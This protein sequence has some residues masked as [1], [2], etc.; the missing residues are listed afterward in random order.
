MNKPVEKLYDAITDID[1]TFIEKAE[2][3]LPTTKKRNF[4][5]RYKHVFIGLAACICLVYGVGFF[6][7]WEPAAGGG[8]G[9]QGTSYMS[10]AGPIFPLSS[11]SD[12]NGIEVTRHTNWDF[13]P[14][15]SNYTTEKVHA[16]IPENTETYTYDRYK[17]ESIVTDQYV[18]TN[19]TDTD[20]TLSLT[21]P[22]AAKFSDSIDVMPKITVDGSVTSADFI[23]GKFSG[24]FT[25]ALGSNA[26]EE[27]LNLDNISS[28]EGYKALLSNDVYFSE[29]QKEFPSLDIPIIVYE[30]SNLAYDGGDEASNPTFAIHFKHDR[31][32]TTIS[33][34][35]WNG[36]SWNRDGSGYYGC[37]RVY[38]PD[39]N[40]RDKGATAYL[41][42]IGEDIETP[43]VQGYRDGG[44][45]KGDEIEG[46][47]NDFKKYET[48]LEDFIVSVC[49]V[50][51]DST[52][53]YIYGPADSEDDSL[54]NLL[55]KD[56]A[57]GYIAQLMYDDGILSGDGIERYGT[58]WLED[59]VY[60]YPQ[61]SRVMYLTFNVTIPAGDS[62][63]VDATMVKEA[64]MDFVGK[65]KH[66]NGYD[67]VT[68]LASPF[69]FT[70]QIA[71]LSN[72]E[73]IIILDQNFGFD[74][75]NGITEVELD[76][77]EEHYWL[78]V[79]KKTT[80]QK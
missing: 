60:D 39:G 43:T 26:S 75:E 55:T 57:L 48:T 77:R 19:P 12:V 6:F 44:C 40:E 31:S 21:Y 34:W 78:D 74:L 41:I 13:A 69:T 42:V 1:E 47:T 46:I 50:E 51:Y 53:D 73:D 52:S 14:Y 18:L 25:P 64:S 28:W 70:K 17:T 27:Q 32:K 80:A 20:I 62:I 22:F 4:I 63:T 33:G 5:Y 36:G 66:R 59:Y 10:Y 67:M 9:S 16:D 37:N 11:T 79:Y 56:M 72:F 2:R 8:S 49:F 71:S 24:S 68:T 29:A 3:T 61:M 30:Y 23:A 76:V 38:T 35:G 54:L 15:K 45:D 7:L 65:N 58:G